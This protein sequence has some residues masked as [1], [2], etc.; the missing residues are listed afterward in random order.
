M[1]IDQNL[2]DEA[3]LRELG[4]RLTGARLA[5][6][7]T[8]AALAVEA[9]ISKRTVER[10]ESGEVATQ[11]SSLIRVCRVLGLVERFDTLVPTALPSPMAQLKLAGKVRQR[12]RGARGARGAQRG[13]RNETVSVAETAMQESARY[14]TA[15]DSVSKNSRK[16]NDSVILSPTTKK[17]TWGE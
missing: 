8:Q 1:I 13:G 17:W 9:G 16:N 5:A 10:L 11:L 15:S 3:L 14:D 2:T 4:S 6:N 7:L 12:A